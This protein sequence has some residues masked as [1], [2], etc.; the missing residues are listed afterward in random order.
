MQ[1]DRTPTKLNSKTKYLY[2][3]TVFYFHR[4]GQ[5]RN[6]Q[7]N[8]HSASCCQLINAQPESYSMLHAYKLYVYPKND[9]IINMHLYSYSQQ[10]KLLSDW[11]TLLRV[12]FDE[13][14][15]RFGKP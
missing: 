7:S 3:K 9:V 5:V 13:I 12:F 6:D 14:Y 2:R 15:F 10:R 11:S 1:N 8:P 4:L